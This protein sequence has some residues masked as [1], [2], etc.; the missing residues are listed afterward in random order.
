MSVVKFSTRTSAGSQTI[1]GDLGGATPKV[2][3]FFTPRHAA[4]N[5][6]NRTNTATMGIGATDGTRQWAGVIYSQDNVGNTNSARC[7]HDNACLS[8]ISGTSVITLA[9][10]SSF[11]ADAVALSYSVAEATAREMVCVLLGGADLNAYVGTTGG[12][13]GTK[14]HTGVGFE[15]DTILLASF[16]QS[17]NETGADNADINFGCVVNDGSLTQKNIFWHE[18][19]NTIVGA[20]VNRLSSNTIRYN[21][22]GGGSETTTVTVIGSDGFTTVCSDTVSEPPFGFVALKF[23]GAQF[24]LWTFTTPTSTGNRTDTTPGFEPIGVFMCSTSLTALDST[25]SD[26]GA[27]GLGFSAFT[28]AGEQA[29]ATICVDAIA[30]PT[31][32]EMDCKAHAFQGGI[33]GT[34]CQ[35]IVADF[36]SVQSNGFTLNYTATNATPRYGWALAFGSGAEEDETGLET[37]ETGETGD[38]TLGGIFGSPIF[39]SPIFYSRALTAN[40]GIR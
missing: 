15:A 13:E 29:A 34:G 5:D 2:A 31:N 11:S 40:R 4:S 22:L 26:A 7:A 35:A 23:G 6:P 37:G 28:A 33:S 30:D 21:H 32:T 8:G 19:D 10:F 27:S 38:G 1:T 3:I 18:S 9:A 12:T 39:R 36:V 14:V 17:F 25:S 24:A 20:P 16:A